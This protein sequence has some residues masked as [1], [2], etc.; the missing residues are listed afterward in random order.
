MLGGQL[1][2]L[3][4][5]ITAVH[6]LAHG[7]F[8]VGGI[9]GGAHLGVVAVEVGDHIVALGELAFQRAVEIIEIEVVVA[10]ALAHEH[11]GAGQQAQV[12][13]GVLVDIAFG[14]VAHDAAAFRGARVGDVD[15]Q[16]VLVAVLGEHEQFF[17]MVGKLDAGDIAV[18]VERQLHVAY[19][20]ALD[21]EALH[22][23]RAVLLSCHG[24]LV[25]VAPGV[26][27]IL[28]LALVHAIVERE[29]VFGHLAF[30]VAYPGKHGGIRVEVEGT[31][32]GELLLVHPVG[33]AVDYLVELA[34]GG[35]LALA[36]VEQQF[37]QEQ[38]AFAHKGHHVAVGAPQG[39]FLRTARGEHGQVARLHV[40]D[41]V[42]GGEAVAVDGSGLG[43]QQDAAL[44]GAEDVAVYMVDAQAS[45]DVV[46]IEEH[47]GL[48]AGLERVGDDFPSVAAHLG[49]ALAIGQRLYAM[50]ALGGIGTLA[51]V[52]Q[53]D[54]VGLGLQ[55]EERQ[56]GHD[57]K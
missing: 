1:H 15:V 39:H 56:Q 41:V 25:A 52:L 37:H 51:E 31:A 4:L 14:M 36:V 40:V 42:F 43:L 30:I 49:I 29:R 13:V 5:G 38:V 22:L 21:V 11:E 3:A 47:T 8:L 9:I 48:L 57:G 53:V 20:A 6:G 54:V 26:V 16:L 34:V 24:V 2:H 19:L 18:R 27:G 55:A 23:H 32:E 12:L 33:L 17:G 7:G 44:V 35:H 45:L 46:G 10:A 50:D 28:G